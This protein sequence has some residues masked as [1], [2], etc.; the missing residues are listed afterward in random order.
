[1]TEL[2]WFYAK[3]GTQ[4]GPRSLSQITRLINNQEVVADMKVWNDTGDWLSASSQPQLH[5]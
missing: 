2:A 5:R 3:N 4:V 1:M